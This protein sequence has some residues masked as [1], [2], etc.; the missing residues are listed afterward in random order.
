M[1]KEFLKKY[2]TFHG[3]VWGDEPSSG[4]KKRI[5]ELFRVAE[6]FVHEAKRNALSL[7]ANALTYIIILSMVPVLA[8]GTAVLKGLGT[9]NQMKEAV[10]RFVEQFETSE[11]PNPVTQHL[12]E[13][14]DKIFE[15]VDRTNFATLGLFGIAGL[16]WAVL[17]TLGKIEAAMNAIWKVDKPRPW[18]RKVIDYTALTVILPLSLNLAIGATA[19]GQLR[20]FTSVVDR[21]LPFPVLNFVLIK[22]LPVFIIVATFSIL[23]RFLPNTHVKPS[24]ALV[25]GLCGGIAWII[26]QLLY[27]KLQIGVTKYNAIYGS[28]ATIP[29]F[30]IWI[31]MGWLMF[32]GGAQ[33]SFVYQY[34]D[35]YNP[36][37]RLTPFVRLSLAIRVLREVYKAFYRG[38]EFFVSRSLL[39]YG[40]VLAVIEPLEKGGIVKKTEKGGYLPAKALEVLKL[41]EVMESV[42]GDKREGIDEEA[43]LRAFEAAKRELEA[44]KLQ[45]I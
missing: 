4:V 43:A 36:F 41:S 22:L 33:L 10:Y 15:Y 39:P 31:N 44:F 11:Q 38:E 23:Y 12:R 27:V 20:K 13:A 1:K 35:S 26:V 7:R 6:F 18:D 34:K 42:F 3:W 32:L 5:R 30:L 16:I 45:V 14:V 28:F 19:L 8:L 9:Q 21:F 37:V 40:F 17:S 25:G 2:G 29:L 24:A